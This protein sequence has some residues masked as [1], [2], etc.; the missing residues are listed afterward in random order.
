MILF[1][2]SSN[3]DDENHIQ[4]PHPKNQQYSYQ[5][6]KLASQKICANIKRGITNGIKYL[7]KI[8]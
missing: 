2:Q 4:I 3:S 1:N 7:L 8:L 6:I 5:S